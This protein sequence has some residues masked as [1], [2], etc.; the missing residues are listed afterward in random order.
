MLRY[1]TRTLLL[2]TLLCGLAVA[3]FARPYVD[4]SAERQAILRLEKDWDILVDSEAKLGAWQN[5]KIP[6]EEKAS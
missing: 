1:K 5:K 3:I 6:A 2:L 4:A